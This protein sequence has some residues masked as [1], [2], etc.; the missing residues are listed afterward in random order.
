[1]V[2]PVDKLDE[3]LKSAGIEDFDELTEAEKDSY[4]KMLD[5]A[6]HSVVTLE[7][8]KKHVKRMRESI[9]MSLVSDDMAVRRDLFLKAR[10]KCYLL[11]ESFFEKPER[12]S[13][14]LDQFAKAASFKKI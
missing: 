3:V 9:E 14:I 8:F 13:E 6:Q 2:S 12:A 4:M 11:F 5:M 1:M 10:L 7:D